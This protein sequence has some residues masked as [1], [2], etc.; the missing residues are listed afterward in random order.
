MLEFWIRAGELLSSPAKS[1]WPSDGAG[2]LR[3][4]GL[5]AAQCMKIVRDTFNDRTRWRGCLATQTVSTA[6]TRYMLEGVAYFRVF[7]LSPANSL[8]VPDLF[9]DIGVTGYFGDI[10]DSR[11]INSITKA[12]PAV[13]TSP[14]HA[15]KNG[16]RLKLSVGLGMIELNDKFVTVANA[17]KDT[18]E[19]EGIDSTSYTTSVMHDRNYA[20]L[21][22][23]FE[24]MDES[25]DKFIAE[26]ANCPT[27]YTHF[28]RVMAASWLNGSSGGVDTNVSVASL[29]DK[30]W[31][32]QKVIADENGLE[33]R[34]YEGG[35]HFV[36]D[37]CLTG[38]GGNP[39]FTEYLVNTAHTQE[40]A[41]VYAAMYAAFFEIG[42]HFPAK[43][44]EGGPSSRY[45]SWG[46]MRF[47]PG[48]E[49]NAVWMT[50]R[51]ANGL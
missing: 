31:P 51:A 43:F 49:G 4:Y 19:L 8:G 6:V 30:F 46:A 10:Q 34:Q 50:T 16:Q 25:N 39:Q 23:L 13:V 38:Y 26:P 21:A 12:N 42:G 35:L 41:D 9:N 22:L 33:L 15:Y 45:G 27:K 1:I 17:T 20:N 29:R 37:A 48:D 40:T 11:P 7:Q 36:G 44:V 32:A 18:F 3:W 2:F 28:N 47:I 24:L 14:S 5:R